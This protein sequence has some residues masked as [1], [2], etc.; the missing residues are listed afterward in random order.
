MEE[1]EQKMGEA[2]FCSPIGVGLR[3][4][5][6]TRKENYRIWA[7]TYFM[8]RAVRS[9]RGGGD[10][11]Y[12]PFL[13]GRA[14]AAGREGGRG[15]GRE[16]TG[17]RGSAGAINVSGACGI[18]A[19]K[20]RS[21]TRFHHRVTDVDLERI[22]QKS[23]LL[24]LSPLPSPPPPR[25]SRVTPAMRGTRLPLTAAAAALGLATRVE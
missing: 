20:K 24:S 17:D 19:G 16:I 7:N 13:L 6:H 15:R 3:R 1:D 4:R 11:V 23:S 14:R 10:G 5:R 9:A 12:W 25:H 8:S 22:N 21:V 2:H 18:P